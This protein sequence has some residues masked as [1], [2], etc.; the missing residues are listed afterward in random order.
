MQ[1]RGNRSGA[2]HPREPVLR[3]GDQ[4]PNVARRTSTRSMKCRTRPGSRTG[5]GRP[6]HGRRDSSRARGPAC[7]PGAGRLDGDFGQERWRDAG[8]TVRFRRAGLV[9]QVRSARL[10]CHG[11]WHGGP[12]RP[13]L[14][15]AGLSRAGDAPA[16]LRPEELTIDDQARITSPSGN[17]RRFK[18]SD[19]RLLL[20][21]AHRGPMDRLASSPARRS[22]GSPSA[23]SD[24]T[25]RGPTIPT[26]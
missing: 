8:F 18:E 4:T 16:T 1:E 25:A 21:E 5:W 20:R 19:I 22:K 12:R 24:S 15:G 2:R 3:P 14:L 7:P 11:D 6:R 10:S 26:M 17:R 9:H 23:V 13:A